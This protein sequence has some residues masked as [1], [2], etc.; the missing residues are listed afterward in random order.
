MHQHTRQRAYLNLYSTQPN[1]HR[2]SDFINTGIEL[3]NLL[4]SGMNRATQIN[5]NGRIVFYQLPFKRVLSRLIIFREF[6]PCSIENELWVYSCNCLSAALTKKRINS[7]QLLVILAAVQS[8]RP[9]HYA[10]INYVSAKVLDSHAIY[11]T[12]SHIIRLKQNFLIRFAS[13]L[14]WRKQNNSS[15]K[16]YIWRQQWCTGQIE[17]VSAFYE[18]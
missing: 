7:Y 8:T 1:S 4:A 14:I 15:S 18:H 5:K 10:L 16:V 9:H 13:K 3:I 6:M 12:W 17:V 11:V 2:A